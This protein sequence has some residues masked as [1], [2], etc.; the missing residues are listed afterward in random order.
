[1]EQDSEEFPVRKEFK[2]QIG[3]PYAPVKWYMQKGLTRDRI[4]FSL[5]TYKMG[6]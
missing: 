3:I 2:G 4:S 5:F 1:M 6:V